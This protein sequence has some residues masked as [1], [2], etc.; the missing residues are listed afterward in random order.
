M[1]TYAG[2]R[3]LDI[4]DLIPSRPLD[5]A[6]GG[7]PVPVGG[8]RPRGQALVVTHDDPCSPCADYLRRLDGERDR[9]ATEK[10]ELVALVGPGWGAEGLPRASAVADATVRAWLVAGD[11]PA[12]VVAD[13]FGQIFARFDAAGH[14]FPDPDRVVDVLFDIAIRCPECGVPDVPWDTTMPEPGAASG[15]MRLGQ[16]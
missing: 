8:N 15:G 5:A 11:D 16:G 14:D 9:L 10:A 6:G 7:R 12:V 4:G 13:Q 1:G 2:T 3:R